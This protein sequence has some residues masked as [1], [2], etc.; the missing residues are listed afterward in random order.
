[1]GVVGAPRLSAARC[2]HGRRLIARAFRMPRGISGSDD[3]WFFTRDGLR[4]QGRLSRQAMMVLREGARGRGM[5]VQAAFDLWQYVRF[6][7]RDVT[8]GDNKADQRR[9]ARAHHR[10]LEALLFT[11]LNH[12]TFDCQDEGSSCLQ[13][14]RADF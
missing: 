12:D 11:L 2:L 9:T 1:M 6:G 10:P 13:D 4:V 5:Y 3:S 8:A 7:L 14:Q